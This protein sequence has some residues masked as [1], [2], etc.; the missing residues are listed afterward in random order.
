[1]RSCA[2]LALLL[3]RREL[4]HDLASPQ[5]G[6]KCIGTAAT[7]IVAAVEEVSG[8]D[9]LSMTAETA[10]TTDDDGSSGGGDDDDG[11][12]DDDK[13]KG[14]PI[15]LIV[16]PIFGVLVLAAI[17]GAIMFVQKQNKDKATAKVPTDE[18]TDSNM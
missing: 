13:K 12:D 5:T 6:A 14:P 1:M 9:G 15:G 18:I 4:I 7:A 3:Q 10:A 8:V 17:I 16:G 11:N 2:T